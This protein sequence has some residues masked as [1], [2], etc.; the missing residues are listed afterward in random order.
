M[1]TNSQPTGATA[2]NGAVAPTMNGKVPQTDRSDRVRKR[3]VQSIAK[4][5][6][7]G[8]HA[9]EARLEELDVEWDAERSFQAGAAAL[10]LI[11]S[12][13]AARE[14]RFLPLPAVMAGF[15]LGHAM[16]GRCPPIGLMRAIGFRTR[17]EIDHERYA[18]KAA[19]GDFDALD[20]ASAAGPNTLLTVTEF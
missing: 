1:S 9:I 13:L 10:I 5:M 15:V 16:S 7:G 6:E 2:L 3:T 20:V 12:A 18:L 8:S 17:R 14:R 4:A 11:G 19:R